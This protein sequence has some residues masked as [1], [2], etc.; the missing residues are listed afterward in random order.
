MYWGDLAILLA[1]TT[2]PIVFTFVFIINLLFPKRITIFISAIIAAL[3]AETILSQF[4]GR[5]WGDRIFHGLI[6]ST[7]QG[8]ISYNIIKRFIKLKPKH[9][10]IFINSLIVLFFI[11]TVGYI[12]L[13]SNL[14]KQVSK[15]KKE[16]IIKTEKKVNKYDALKNHENPTDLDI[17][18]QENRILSNRDFKII[19]IFN[20]LTN[21]FNIC[22]VPSSLGPSCKDNNFDS[23]KYF[24]N[25]FIYVE[26]E[27]LHFEFDD[28]DYY[29]DIIEISDKEAIIKFEDKAKHASYHAIS[30][31]KFKYNKFKSKWFVHSTKTLYPKSE[32]DNN[33]VLIS[34]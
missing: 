33:F 30:M 2:D 18:L 8:L 1:R 22:D 9:R 34:K 19:E 26:N 11:T 31:I 21:N 20:K 6:G 28:W 15:P 24:R 17:L 32:A 25:G 10:K 3:L 14:A 7:I 23:S 13:M 29:F 16:E 12:I 27:T 4:P 5:Y